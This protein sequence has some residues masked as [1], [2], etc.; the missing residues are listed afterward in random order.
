MSAA[1][2]V[3]FPRVRTV[4]G[5]CQARLPHP[6][7]YFDRTL[8]IHV[9]EHLPD[10]PA[11]AREMYRLCD[12]ARGTFSVVIPCEG[13]PAYTLARRVSA[14]RIF[15]RRYKQPYK[16]FIEREHIN[17]PRELLEERAPYFTVSHRRFFPFPFVPAAWCNLVIGLTLRP[18]AHAQVG[19]ER[20][21]A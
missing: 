5:D 13:S 3:R 16:W 17:R 20:A 6:D 4:T 2:R 8:A 1:I 7:G 14:Q 11:A 18:P 19:P 12:K 10:L 15:E 9:L 21:A